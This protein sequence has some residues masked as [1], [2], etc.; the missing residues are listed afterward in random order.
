MLKVFLMKIRPRKSC[1]YL[2]STVFYEVRLLLKCFFVVVLF[3]YQS[4]LQYVQQE[5]VVHLK[6]SSLVS[7]NVNSFVLYIKEEREISCKSLL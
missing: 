3:T 4:K 6:I 7:P 1:L 5:H 2:T